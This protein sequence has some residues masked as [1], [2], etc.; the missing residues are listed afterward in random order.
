MLLSG[1]LDQLLLKEGEVQVGPGLEM[2]I[3]GDCDSPW[4]VCPH[5]HGVPPDAIYDGGG[6]LSNR[7]VLRDPVRQ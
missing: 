1:Y 2:Q 5:P 6:T 3:T 4:S 7:F